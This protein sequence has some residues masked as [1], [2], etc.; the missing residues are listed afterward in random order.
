MKKTIEITNRVGNLYS[1]LKSAAVEHKLVKG[2][3]I[4]MRTT[5]TQGGWHDNEFDAN[6]AGFDI[7]RFINPAYEATRTFAE[8]Y[9]F[10]KK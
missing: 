9:C 1:F 6:Q 3:E 4:V 2:D 8:C 5:Y 7:C 10:I